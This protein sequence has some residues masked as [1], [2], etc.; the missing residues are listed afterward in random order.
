MS[1]T[2]TPTFLYEPDADAGSFVMLIAQE[3]VPTVDGR[4]FSSG[5]I[6]WRELPI[7]LTMNRKN[8]AEGQH[9]T[10]EG[11]GAITEVWRDGT[12][13]YGRGFFSSDEAGQEARSLIKEGTISH[14][15]ADVGGIVVQELSAEE[16]TQYPAG[17]TKLF[18]RGTII[19]VTALLHSSFDDTKIA[20]EDAITA[21]AATGW[22]PPA[23]AFKNPRLTK[24]TPLTVTEDGR[25]FGH[26]AT[27]GTCHV[28]Y[29]DRC[30]QPPRSR[31][32]YA[33]F[34][35]GE[36]VTDSGEKVSVGRITAST[37]HAPIEFGAQPAKE[38]YDHTG[39]AAAYVHTGEDE[40]GIWFSGVLAPDATP[41]QVA[42]LRAAGVSGDWRNI[43]G[44]LEMVG[45]LAV[46]TPGFP[47]PRAQANIVAGAQMALVAAGVVV[48]EL[49]EDCGCGCKGEGDCGKKKR[50]GAAFAE[51]E[52]DDEEE[53]DDTEDETEA[54]DTESLEAE[55]CG[56]VEGFG[57][58]GGKPIEWT[59]DYDTTFLAQ[60]RDHM[61]QMYELASQVNETGSD[62]SLQVQGYASFL[63][64]M[65]G[66]EINYL[67]RTLNTG[68]SKEEKTAMKEEG[69]EINEAPE[70]A[71]STE[72]LSIESRLTLLDLDIE[73][74]V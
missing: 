24:P 48:E 43:D 42:N 59:T 45:L 50:K 13:I 21:A 57:F 23:D 68:M 71:F 17:V 25:V 19:G 65:L 70:A 61:K 44:T 6:D 26:A 33:Y 52:T 15:S 73:L 55:D 69:K 32:Q 28:G 51:D 41:A 7:P 56:C 36:V 30:V 12:N 5:A 74:S 2:A 40:F 29:K 31:K 54:E 66:Q 38:H 14:V 64:D 16:M 8:S 20:V 35:I 9:K 60:I 58:N 53:D 4:M 63:E 3:N 11:V 39:F 46:N 37:G 72:E 62:T 67:D 1:D 34:N 10:A 27:W 22:A 18:R 47:V 49:G